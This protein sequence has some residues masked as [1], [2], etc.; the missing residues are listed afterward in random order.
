[1]DLNLS[2]EYYTML[3][4]RYLR[5]ASDWTSNRQPVFPKTQLVDSFAQR[6]GSQWSFLVYDR[7]PCYGSSVSKF[8]LGDILFCQPH[9]R[10]LLFLE[11]TLSNSDW[12]DFL[13]KL[14]ASCKYIS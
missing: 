9:L 7:Y 3:Y 2:Q 14:P 6:M 5:F 13:L 8:L 1:M 11:F 12:L 10:E 4:L